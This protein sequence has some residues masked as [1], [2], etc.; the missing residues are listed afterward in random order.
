MITSAPPGTDA[1]EPAREDAFDPT[2]F[3]FDAYP[4][5]IG[6]SDL[7]YAEHRR[8]LGSAQTLLS[9]CPCLHG[10]PSCVG[11]TLEVGNRA[12]E[13]ALTVVNRLLEQS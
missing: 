4:G 6:F 8:L 9:S 7:L 11:P 12:K 1:E 10:C 13:V 2:V 3:L 5:G